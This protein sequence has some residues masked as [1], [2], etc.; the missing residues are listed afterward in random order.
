MCCTYIPISISNF[1]RLHKNKLI[2]SI[3]NFI[4]VTS[5]SQRWPLFTK[6]A[7]IDDYIVV[8]W[9]RVDGRAI[10]TLKRNH[11]MRLQMMVAYDAGGFFSARCSVFTKYKSLEFFLVKFCSHLIKRNLIFVCLQSMIYL[12]I[13]F[14]AVVVLFYFFFFCSCS[15][16]MKIAY[17][18]CRL[19]YYIQKSHADSMV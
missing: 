2:Y 13:F 18:Y 9:M 12:L 5:S 4:F 14:F 3:D 1:Y 19:C 15:T 17:K 7:F 11:M 10:I 6:L 16:L 8:M